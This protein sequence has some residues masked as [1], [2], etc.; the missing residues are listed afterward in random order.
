MKPDQVNSDLSPIT[1]MI[2][3]RERAAYQRG[4]DDAVA[5]M[6]AAVG[7]SSTAVSTATSAKVA[8][9]GKRK[10]AARK[11]APEKASP[12]KKAR[13]HVLINKGPSKARAIVLETIQQNPGRTGTEIALMV[14]ATV[15][16]HTVRTQLR[17]LKKSGEIEQTA[18][19]RWYAR[20]EQKQAA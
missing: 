18:A 3:E 6:T 20:G 14:G 10:K 17:K 19:L 16:K 11:A 1:Q 2:A 15:N 12:K 13:K 7:A 5:A 8:R 4:W 9:G